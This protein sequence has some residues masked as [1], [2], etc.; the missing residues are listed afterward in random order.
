ME[1]QEK[2]TL[3]VQC[4]YALDSEVVIKALGI[5]GF[6]SRIVIMPNYYVEYMVVYYH[7]GARKT[8]WFS[9]AELDSQASSS[10]QIR[11]CGL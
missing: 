1:T 11:H 3:I 9:E 8:D 5:S 2:E 6:V 10:L 4:R 7:E